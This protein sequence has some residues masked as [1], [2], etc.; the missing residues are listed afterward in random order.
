ML[1]LSDGQ[2]PHLPAESVL[3]PLA[4]TQRPTTRCRRLHRRIL[5]GDGS[6][7]AADPSVSLPLGRC[8]EDEGGVHVTATGCQTESVR[9]V[10]VG[11]LCR[12]DRV[13]ARK[14]HDTPHLR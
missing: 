9:Q 11:T 7:E 2:R 8:R 1:W 12:L 13:E 5:L 4:S 6:G 10:V 3:P 14:R